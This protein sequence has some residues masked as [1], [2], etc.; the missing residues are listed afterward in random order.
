M[1]TV[2]YLLQNSFSSHSEEMKLEIKHFWRHIP[3]NF[4]INQRGKNKTK[5]NSKQELQKT[6]RAEF[7]YK[8]LNHNGS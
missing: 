4:K 7:L 3:K 1:N 6:R 8:T 2:D 5:Q